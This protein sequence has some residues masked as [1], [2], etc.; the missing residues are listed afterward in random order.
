MSWLD[1]AIAFFSPKVAYRREAWRKSYEEIRNYDAGAHDRL[2]AGWQAVNSTAEQTDSFYRDTVRARGRDL[3]RNSDMQ[4]SIIGAFERNVVGTG[5]KL[6]AKTDDENLNDAI[7]E[8]WKEW[9]KP[10]NCDVT[11]QQSFDEMVR[12][13]ERRKKI[14]GGILF[15]KRY[16]KGGVVPFVLQVRE[17]DDLDTMQNNNSA[18][19]RIINGIEYNEYNRPIAYY[20]KQYDING[21]YSG[22]SE[23]IKADDVIFLWNKKRPSQIR[24]M[25]DMAP[26]ITRIKDVN[27]YMEAV[28]VKERVAAC[29]SV[30]I[31]RQNPQPGSIGRTSKSTSNTY[32]GKTLS[33]GMISELNPG[34]D[35]SVVNPPAQGASA[36]DFVRV[37]QRLTGSGQ[38][39]SYEAVARDMSQVNYSSARQGLL[40]DQKTYAMEQQYLIDHLL[41]EVYETFLISAVLSGAINIKDFWSD[42]KKYMKHDWTPP[43]QKWIDPVKE[44]NANKTALQTNQAT[45]ADIAASSGQD[46]KEVVDQRAREI[47]YMKQKGV[48]EIDDTG[49]TKKSTA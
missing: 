34:D 10:R 36:A 38:G 37:Q 13:A 26:T 21:F 19:T 30:F 32:D 42:K 27:S 25:S 20:F 2:N 35:V 1:S 49:K 48:I 9:R 16:T 39:I 12:M 22:K 5:F 18:S 28:S 6:Q 46:W 15:V 40:E 31:K 17:V 14:D 47:E 44:V 45:L 7:E 4:E 29:L 8:L 43:G 41:S 33:P 11:A 3:E 24:E 23:K